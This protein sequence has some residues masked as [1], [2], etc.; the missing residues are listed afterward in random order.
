MKNNNPVAGTN[1]SL[2]KQNPTGFY[3]GLPIINT[4]EI[5]NAE[6][7]RGAAQY[8]RVNKVVK[9]N[10]PLLQQKYQ[11]KAWTRMR[12]LVETIHGDEYTKE[13]FAELTTLLPNLKISIDNSSRGNGNPNIITTGRSEE[14]RRAME[15][16]Q[17][18]NLIKS[19]SS[20][21]KRD[22]KQIGVST[23]IYSGEVVDNSLLEYISL[24]TPLTKSIELL[25]GNI[26][27]VVTSKAQDLPANQFQT[28]EQFE[29]F[30]IEHEFQ[31]SI[32]SRQDFNREFPQGTKGDYETEINKRAIFALGLGIPLDIDKND[33][34][35]N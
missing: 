3:K 1:R 7:Q 27:T 8:D 23:F 10:K 29:N 22:K 35:C 33:L 13:L 26:D 16:L 5:V 30:V 20:K 28:Y 31:H 4:T 19:F 2:Q 17:E 21:T 9:I 12:E 6:G 18:L 32:Y 11:E 24:G 15:I 14:D 34:K 25:Q